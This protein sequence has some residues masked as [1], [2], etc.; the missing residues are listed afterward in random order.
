MAAEEETTITLGNVKS[1]QPDD[2]LKRISLILWGR[3]GSFKTTLASTAPGKKLWIN[4]DPDGP[5]SLIGRNEVHH[6]ITVL[7]LSGEHENIVTKFKERVPPE[8][9]SKWAQYDTI[10]VDSLTTFGET[11]LKHGVTVAQ[12]T[13]KG[14]SSTLEDPGFAGYGMKYTWMSLMV[15]NLNHETRRANKHIIFICHEDRLERDKEGN[16]LF[17]SILLGSSLVEQVPINLSEVWHVEDTGTERRIQVR[18]CRLFRPMKSRMFRTDKDPEFVWKYDVHTWKGDGIAEWH[19]RW[20]ANGGKKI[21]L[22][23]G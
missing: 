2:A 10:V 11:A 19:Q 3:A 20:L 8:I 22:P 13:A 17:I 18:N 23:K 14:R 21:E 7:D 6:D 9:T 1:G 16:P 4:F 12:G 5:N 15:R